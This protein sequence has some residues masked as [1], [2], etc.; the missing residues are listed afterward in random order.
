[1]KQKGGV[2]ELEGDVING[3]QLPHNHPKMRFSYLGKHKYEWDRTEPIRSWDLPE[4]AKPHFGQ[5]S[6]RVLVIIT[7]L[8]LWNTLV[9]I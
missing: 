4:L 8:A 9:Y 3:V 1:M 6:F 2:R 5:S 7:R